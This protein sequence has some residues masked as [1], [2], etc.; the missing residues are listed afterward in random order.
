[1]KKE[2]GRQAG[3]RIAQ[4]NGEKVG[5]SGCQPQQRQEEGYNGG[6]EKKLERETN[7]PPLQPRE[8]EREDATVAKRR[9]RS[10]RNGIIAAALEAGNDAHGGHGGGGLASGV[11]T[12]LL[13]D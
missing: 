10:Q 1:M 12:P 6:R 4:R 11:V 8:R 7:K 9:K 5:K 2:A 3:R 13:I